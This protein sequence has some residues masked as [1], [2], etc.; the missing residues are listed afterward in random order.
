M[1]LIRF[2]PRTPPQGNFRVYLFEEFKRVQASLD[3]ILEAFTSL[4]T[5]RSKGLDIEVGPPD[6][7]GAGYRSLRIKN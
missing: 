4:R 7:A 3:S 5:F 2:V 1:A 6:S